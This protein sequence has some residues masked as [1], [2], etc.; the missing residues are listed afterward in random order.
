MLSQVNIEQNASDVSSI[1][2]YDIFSHT[3]SE[4]LRNNANSK[5]QNE[6]KDDNGAADEVIVG[7]D[8]SNPTT[9]DSDDYLF[10]G[11]GDDPTASLAH[12]GKQQGRI[13][14]H[15]RKR[16][17]GTKVLVNVTAPRIFTS[18]AAN[19]YYNAMKLAK[20][21]G[22]PAERVDKS[23]NDGKAGENGSKTTS[24]KASTD[25]KNTKKSKKNGSQKKG[26]QTGKKTT[27]EQLVSEA[28]SVAKTPEEIAQFLLAQDGHASSSSCGH[29]KKALY[30]AI[31]AK[32]EE[33]QIANSVSQRKGNNRQSVK[34]NNAVPKSPPAIPPVTSL[35]CSNDSTTSSITHTSYTKNG[36]VCSAITEQPP[37]AKTNRNPNSNV[38]N[39]NVKNSPAKNSDNDPPLAEYPSP[40]CSPDEDTLGYPT[41]GD[42]NYDEYNNNTNVLPDNLK[43]DAVHE[44]NIGEVK[45]K[46]YSDSSTAASTIP[47]ATTNNP[48]SV[49]S[50]A[51]RQKINNVLETHTSAIQEDFFLLEDNSIE[52]DLKSFK[53]EAIRK[54][55]NAMSNKKPSE[56]Y[57]I[58]QALKVTDLPSVTGSVKLAKNNEK[59]KGGKKISGRGVVRSMS[60]IMLF[61]KKKMEVVHSST[62]ISKKGDNAVP[63]NIASSTSKSKL[64]LVRSMSPSLFSSNPNNVVKKDDKGSG[65]GG[66]S[67]S[68]VSTAASSS[69]PASVGSAVIFLPPSY[70]TDPP[71]SEEAKKSTRS[72]IRAAS[73]VVMANRIM[74][75]IKPIDSSSKNTAEIAVMLDPRECIGSTTIEN[76]SD[77][78]SSSFAAKESKSPKSKNKALP[79]RIP[80]RPVVAEQQQQ[81]MQNIIT[82]SDDDGSVECSVMMDDDEEEMLQLATDGNGVATSLGESGSDSSA[83]TEKVET[84]PLM[85]TSADDMS[86][87]VSMLENTE[88]EEM[89]T[90]R[91][92]NVSPKKRKKSR[93]ELAKENLAKHQPKS[94][95][96]E[97][98]KEGKLLAATA[99]SEEDADDTTITSST[100]SKIR[101][102]EKLKKI[103]EYRNKASPT[104]KKNLPQKTLDEWSVAKVKMNGANEAQKKKALYNGSGSA[105]EEI[106]VELLGLLHEKE[107]KKHR[108]E[109]QRS[110][111]TTSTAPKMK[112]GNELRDYK[113]KV[114]KGSNTRTKVWE[115]KRSGIANLL[116]KEIEEDRERQ[117]QEQEQ[118]QKK[119]NV[120]PMMN[121]VNQD[122]SH[123]VKQ[124]NV[125]LNALEYDDDDV[126]VSLPPELQIGKKV[127]IWEDASFVAGNKD[128]DDD[129]N[130][131][132]LADNCM[133]CGAHV[134]GYGDAT[135]IDGNTTYD[136][137]TLNEDS[138]TILESMG[139]L[140]RDE[141]HTLGDIRRGGRRS[142]STSTASRFACGVD[143]CQL[144]NDLV[145][146]A[147]EVAKDV[148]YGV[149]RS[150][151]NLFGSCDITQDGGVDFLGD[152]VNTTHEQLFG[153]VPMPRDR[154]PPLSTTSQ[155]S[156]P[157]AEKM[158]SILNG[159]DVQRRQHQGRVNMSQKHE[160]KK[161]ISDNEKKIRYLEKLKAVSLRHL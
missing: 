94:P 72:G 26:Q 37:Q 32:H 22:T 54:G 150:I 81:E 117:Q 30:A 2:D 17:D 61:K 45:T 6:M 159:V 50:G 120:V 66:R 124:I 108:R 19:N 51:S 90:P 60:P 89:E 40:V 63:S 16:S 106:R 160:Q 93:M 114:S 20:M 154:S 58:S 101:K 13:T 99:P 31:L 147:K 75:K 123:P 128:D 9:L 157:Q 70:S 41:K 136:I 4:V 156:N 86:V 161:S 138:N 73:P 11:L 131:Q 144:K 68:D 129:A 148:K 18:D 80:S 62:T 53:N 145:Y 111:S 100:S 88:A 83:K 139:I 14:S 33:Q 107:E 74:N 8:G 116:E 119:P 23:K 91:V 102:K 56:D 105:E 1:P 133:A 125:Y 77:K 39:S 15:A 76:A 57:G 149:R 130:T 24:K 5:K 25:G 78:A 97:E 118:I 98:V 65:G 121:Q 3:K 112:E 132:I 49:I 7:R 104:P 135:E 43:L 35:D 64:R 113:S 151:R 10:A 87:E 84:T 146:E 28:L 27:L 103:M 115:K 12:K 92:T 21:S 142:T 59:Q 95:D 29:D 82:S 134:P 127:R 152:T 79:P 71:V 96:K 143:P 126:D 52:H 153:R 67:T 46:S 122:M 155:K 141:D 137:P 48:A 85:T 47:S 110:Q 36:S 140:S 34:N 44:D 42:G 109:K 38:S 55:V 158:S 69:S